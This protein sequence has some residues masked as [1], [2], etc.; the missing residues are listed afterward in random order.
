MSRV[1][2]DALRDE[3]K[4]ADENLSRMLTAALRDELKDAEAKLRSN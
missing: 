1:L 4:G 2:E 3:L